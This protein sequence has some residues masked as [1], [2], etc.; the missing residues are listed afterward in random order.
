MNVIIN[1]SEKEM[2]IKMSHKQGITF[3]EVSVPFT[4]EYVMLKFR[5]LRRTLLY[6]GLQ[7]WWA[8]LRGSG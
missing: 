8:G 7:Q 4:M 2:E 5:D 1:V 3:L 6:S